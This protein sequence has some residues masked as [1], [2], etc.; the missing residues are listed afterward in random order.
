MRRHARRDVSSGLRST[1]LALAQQ[2]RSS[3]ARQAAEAVLVAHDAFEE[4]GVD[5]FFSRVVSEAKHIVKTGYKYQRFDS[6]SLYDHYHATFRTA[7]DSVESMLRALRW[8][9][10]VKRGRFIGGRGGYSRHLL[11]HHIRIMKKGRIVA[12]GKNLAAIDRYNRTKGH[13]ATLILLQKVFSSGQPS[14]YPEGIAHIYFGDDATVSTSFGSYRI[15]SDW[16][17]GK[18]WFQGTSI[19]EIS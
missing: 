18:K 9:S 3:D 12:R 7:A 16:V 15:M 2:M 17:R 1:L 19:Q 4:L 11:S 6:S 10:K 14:E 5:P 13:G 8:A